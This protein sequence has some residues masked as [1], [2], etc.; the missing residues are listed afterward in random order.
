MLSDSSIY[1]AEGVLTRFDRKAIPIESWNGVV[2]SRGH[3]WGIV[4]AFVVAERFPSFDAFIAQ[5]APLIEREHRAAVQRGELHGQ[6]IISIRALGWSEQVDRPRSY[7]LT[8]PSPLSED[9]S[10][11]WIDDLDGDVSGY[12]FG[13]GLS[14]ADDWRLHREGLE[15]GKDWQPEIFDP[16]RHGIPLM[17]AQRRQLTAPRVFPRPF[18]CV[19]GEIWCSTVTR[20][21]VEQ[22][23]IHEWPDEVG[24][25]IEP[26]ADTKAARLPIV[27]PSFVKRKDE[28]L[29]IEQYRRGE[30]GPDLLPPR[31]AAAPLNRQQRR[32]LARAGR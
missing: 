32:A 23:V 2:S 26:E 16:V 14:L 18:H 19:G 17:E 15:P 24:L 5:S 7:T 12:V 31:P 29:W 21:G 8:S 28:A 3:I 6:T 25:P 13:P 27:A 4:A 1:D 20:E 10:Y 11:V 9:P 22:E 30:I